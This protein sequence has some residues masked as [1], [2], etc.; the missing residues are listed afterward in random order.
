MSFFQELQVS[1]KDFIEPASLKNQMDITD[2]YDAPFQ[3]LLS[4]ARA[5]GTDDSYRNNL[6]IYVD[7]ESREDLEEFIL[8][9]PPHSFEEIER[10]GRTTFKGQDFL[11]VINRVEKWYNPI[12]KWCGNLFEAAKGQLNEELLHVE[13][14]YF[15]GNTTYTPFGIHID[16]ISEALHLNLGPNERYMYLWEPETYKKM[17]GSYEPLINPSPQIFSHSQ[18]YNIEKDNWFFLPASK[19]FHVGENADFSISLAVAMIRLDENELFK[20]AME[21]AQLPLEAP[22]S[23]DVKGIIKQTVELEC[24]QKSGM[25][26]L[27][28]LIQANDPA[29]VAL[30]QYALRMRS[31]LG[32]RIPTSTTDKEFPELSDWRESSISLN[33]PF[34]LLALEK[35]HEVDVFAGGNMMSLIRHDAILDIIKKLNTEFSLSVIELIETFKDEINEDSIYLLCKAFYKYGVLEVK[36]HEYV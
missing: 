36:F 18:K 25:I 5:K 10:W 15:I 24:H 29:E 19:Y 11:V 21:L 31:N 33:A 35:E 28:E 27:T 30:V 16:E 13:V 8:L 14:T 12:V 22:G 7:G 20:R 34:K 32:F 17:R 26:P 6:R 4:M 1:T 23:I 3:T 2:V 9:N